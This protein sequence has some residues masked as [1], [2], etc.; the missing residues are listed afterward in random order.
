MLENIEQ[1]LLSWYDGNARVLPWRERPD[2]YK[3]WV[4]EIM[5]QQTRVEAVKPYFDR[6]LSVLPNI[7][8]LAAV[9]EEKLLKLWEGLGYYNRARN[10][11]KTAK[12]VL[13]R[14]NGKLPAEYE[15]LLTLPG[16]GEYTAGAIAS[17]AYQKPVPAVDGNVLRVITRVLASF[18][19][20][21]LPETK[22]DI[23]Q[24]LLNIIPHDR[25]GDFNQA[26]M[27]LGA[28]VCLPNG[29]PMCLL[30]P[31]REECQSFLEGLTD[32][33]P[34][35]NRKK[36]RKIEQR[37]L[38]ILYHSG[39]V[40]LQKRKKKGL[41]ANL[42][43]YPNYLGKMTRK[44]VS[45]ELDR[46]GIRPIKIEKCGTAKH[47]FTHVEWHMQGYFI[48]AENRGNIVGEWVSLEDMKQNFALPSAYRNFSDKLE[49]K[50]Q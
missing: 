33:I 49:D 38:L 23:R 1:P 6:F 43:E 39:K 47:I 4:S 30:C 36:E 8:S 24:R 37:T 50:I 18:D 22:R 17:I 11:Q 27:E 44:Q 40:L 45:E 46:Q 31:L 48:Q 29:T 16:I 35:K 42:W 13:E 12:I 28:T 14:F 5:L 2:P 26:L 34:V 32:Q 41:L 20:I 9:S 19:N 25:P 10:L 21:S 7:A 15:Q 3:V